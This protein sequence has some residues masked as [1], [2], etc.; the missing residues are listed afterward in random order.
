MCF[1]EID[2]DGFTQT[3][4]RLPIKGEQLTSALETFKIFPVVK[5]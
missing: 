1:I 3:D 4:T 5:R 2:N